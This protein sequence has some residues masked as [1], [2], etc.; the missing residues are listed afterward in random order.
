M[1]SNMGKCEVLQ[2]G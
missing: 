2:L 1:K